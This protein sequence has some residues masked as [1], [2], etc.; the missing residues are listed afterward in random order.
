MVEARRDVLQSR[1]WEGVQGHRADT[2]LVSGHSR[3]FML[4][5]LMIALSSTA[6]CLSAGRR[7]GALPLLPPPIPW[8]GPRPS[9]SS[10]CLR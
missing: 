2:L 5:A 4:P 3:V 9:S 8:S 6:V 1:G 7:D 10:L